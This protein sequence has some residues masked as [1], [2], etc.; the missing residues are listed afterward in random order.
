MISKTKKR[1]ASAAALSAVLAVQSLIPVSA[2]GGTIGA[3]MSTKSPVIRVSVPTK[4]AVSVNEF[5][6]GDE[7]SQVTSDKFTMKN[8][9]EV[10]VNVKVTSTAT[11]GATVAMASTKAAAKASTDK[12]N[13]AMWLAA[14]AA[15][16]AGEYA[17]GSDTTVKALTGTEY[18]VTTFGAKKADDN[19]STAVQNFYLQAATGAAYKGITGAEVDAAKTEIGNGA[20]FYELTAVTPATDDAAG[21]AKLAETQDVY[22]A[23]GTVVGGT[24]QALT[25]IAKG[26]ASA[27]ITGWTASASKAFTMANA[28]TQGSA[29]DN[30]KTYLYIDTA[31]TAAGDAAEFR[32]IGALSEAK[33]GWSTTELSAVSIAYDIVAISGTAYTA[34]AGDDGSKLVY[35]Y[36]KENFTDTTA[37]GNWSGSDLWLSK[38]G[39]DG[40][41]TTGL[42]VEVS[43][44]GTTYKTLTADQYT[45][46]EAGWV[47]TTWANIVAGIGSEP[48]GHAFIRIT[49]G[50]TRYVF[51]NK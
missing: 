42:K 26:T 32:Y 48:S 50:T 18:N 23:A 12:T 4:M 13:P 27:S 43:D 35:G 28:P 14:V 40:F 1:A 30:T 19:T 25:K 29:L 11:V 31:T 44:G 7:G 41:S 33:S 10:P 20:D 22:I 34:V 36:Q 39:T 2:A 51:E 38:D 24:P 8:L 6:M 37:S 21:V 3:D 45:V 46:N 9:S 5:E 17:T 15:V 49:D 16:D 47:S